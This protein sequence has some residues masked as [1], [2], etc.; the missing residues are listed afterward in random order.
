MIVAPI[1]FVCFGWFFLV[2]LGANFLA[3]IFGSFSA[4]VDSRLGKFA[5][6]SSMIWILPLI[7]FVIAIV[8]GA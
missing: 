1:A 6:R 4:R 8:N 5:R 3:W 2:W 7:V